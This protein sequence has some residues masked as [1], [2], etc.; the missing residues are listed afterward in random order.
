[1]KG[2]KI[3]TLLA[4]MCVAMALAITNV[5]V[6]FAADYNTETSYETEQLLVESGLF[7]Y[8]DGQSELTG[9]RK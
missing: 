3:I 4:V 2:K 1:M 7:D 6:A 9:G 5:A 8:L